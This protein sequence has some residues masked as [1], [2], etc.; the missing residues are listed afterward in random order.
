MVHATVFYWTEKTCEYVSKD[1]VSLREALRYIKKT[2]KLLKIA[3]LKYDSATL[4][5]Y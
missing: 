5:I 3:N 2:K 4:F 1:C